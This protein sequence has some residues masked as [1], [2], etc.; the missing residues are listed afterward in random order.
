[1][2]CTAPFKSEVDHNSSI[3][4]H[5]CCYSLFYFIWSSRALQNTSLGFHSVYPYRARSL[6]FSFHAISRLHARTVFSTTCIRCLSRCAVPHLVVHICACAPPRRVIDNPPPL[7]PLRP[8]LQTLAL[9]FSGYAPGA[10]SSLYTFRL[11]SH[12]LCHE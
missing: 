12:A 8:Q 9:R 2:P 3:A 6:H 11:S 5:H 10:L 7:F 1:M 4:S